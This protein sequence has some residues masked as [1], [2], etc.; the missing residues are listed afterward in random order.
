M[1]LG[2]SMKGRAR[3]SSVD[4]LETSFLRA[5]RAERWGSIAVRM[6]LLLLWALPGRILGAGEARNQLRVH[7][8]WGHKSPTAESFYTRLLT[9]DVSLADVATVGFESADRP[10]DGAWIT[11]AGGGD[12]DGVEF[13]LR[14]E[15]KQII[16]ITNLQRIWAD[17]VKQSDPDTVRRLL[18]DPAYRPDSR[19]LTVQMN[20]EGTKGFTLTVDQL[21]EVRAFWIPSLDV[22]VAVGDPATPF[23]QHYRQLQSWA[24]K[25]VLD[26]VHHAPE[27][28]YEQFKA[29]WQDM[30]SPA[31][32][33][34]AQ[35]GPGHIVGLTWDSALYKFGIDRGGGVWNDYGSPER[36]HLWLSCADVAG[37]LSASWKGQHLTDG[38]PV[39]QTSLQKDALA[40][41]VEQFAYPLRGPPTHREGDLPMVLMQKISVQN[42][43]AAAA[44]K[45]L[46]LHY[47]RVLADT[48]ALE[49]FPEESEYF[50]R[51]SPSSDVVLFVSGVGVRVEARD[52]PER[53]PAGKKA[54]HWKTTALAISLDLPAHSSRDV[55]LKLPSPRVRWSERHLLGKLDYTAARQ[56]TLAFWSEYVKQGA[57]FR[58]PEPAVNELFRASLWHALRLPR[59]HGGLEADVK[60]DLPYS[61]FAYDQKGTPWPVNQS[62]YVDYMIY[63]LRGYHALSTEEL[64]AIYRNN[65][66]ANGHVGGYANWGVYTPGMI[67]S[68]AQAF[69]LS[70]NRAAFESLLPQTLNALDWCLTEIAK[71]TARSGAAR[72]L[73]RAP[74]NDGTGDG[75]WA[76]NQAYFYASLDRLGMAL[77][78]LSHPRASECVAA[79][80]IF[81]DAVERGFGAASMLSPLVQLRD[82][83]WIPYVPCEVL[84]PQRIYQQWYPTDV[85]TGATH[86][87]RLEALDPK[88]RLTDGLLADHEDN[89]FLHG[90]G[91]ANEPV[92]NPQA[93]AYLL[94]DDPVAAIRAF[95]SMMACAFSHSTF[96]PVEHR[97]TWGQYFGPP[98]TDGAWF[99]LYR[100]ML[101]R[102]Q[103]DNSLLLLAATPRKWLQDGKAVSVEGAPSYYGPISFTVRS[104][105]ATG[106][107]RAEIQMPERSRP[108]VLLVRLRHPEARPLRAVTVN[109]QAWTDFDPNKE[110]VRIKG[111]TQGRYSVVALY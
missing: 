36:F 26:E 2:R 111:P 39:I 6:S 109:G 106:K 78:R 68:V 54:E 10:D 4:H 42:P 101:I 84:T 40:C 79:A 105:A 52:E 60:I 47:R 12:V 51:E 95:Y 93:T 23:D 83:T 82:H 7:V 64:Q 76:F 9:N 108:K 56:Q 48:A 62:V 8:S 71:G 3:I 31:Y 98:S 49:L 16:T 13:T 24:G 74:L 81:H 110:W 35:T 32:K 28:S 29:L 55:L 75:V 96:E 5:G 37:D 70:G 57:Q 14:F 53:A 45:T 65:Q 103:D 33:N 50:V 38:L 85:D 19:K 99:D 72:G 97:W 43:D 92:Y 80:K 44:S 34:P 17:L 22:C 88:G 69:L 63:D 30:G 77:T 67:Y 11:R 41:D 94:R 73:V 20:P 46:N 87:P 25:Q 102:E 21:L 89:L 1:N 86:L 15:P 61:N 27:A 91:L 100:H 18:Q 58:V 90:W 107:L 104:E 59:R 66:E